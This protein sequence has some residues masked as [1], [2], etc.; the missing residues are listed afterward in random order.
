M[1]HALCLSLLLLF[2]A[3]VGTAT[4]LPAPVT[5]AVSAPASEAVAPAGP[6]LLAQIFAPAP[7]TSAVD[8]APAPRQADS[9]SPG[10]CRMMC[11]DACGDCKSV[12]LSSNACLCGCVC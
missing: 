7:L 12:C 9:C 3:A 10:V 8:Q 2:V 5:A 1:K 6:A 4:P 11:F